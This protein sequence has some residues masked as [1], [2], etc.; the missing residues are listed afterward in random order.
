MQ[1]YQ[2]SFSYVAGPGHLSVSGRH[3]DGDVSNVLIRFHLA[4]TSEFFF[5]KITA[6]VPPPL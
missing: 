4:M 3:V 1:Q 5:F 6:R 2:P